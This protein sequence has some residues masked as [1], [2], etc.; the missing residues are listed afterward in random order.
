VISAYLEKLRVALSF[1]PSLARCVRQEVEDH[2]REAVAADPIGDGLAAERAIADFGDPNIIAAQFAVIS[3]MKRTRRVGIAV[4]AV[5]AVIAGAFMAMK[6]RIAWYGVMQQLVVNEDVRTVSE[7]VA[8]I[9]RYA[10]W[11]SLIIGVVG[12]TYIG[13]RRVPAVFHPA[14]RR[15]LNRCF[16]LCTLATGAPVISVISDGVLTALRLS[17]TQWSA[18]FLVPILSALAEIAGA[19]FLVSQ[20]RNIARRA[21]FIEANLGAR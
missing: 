20:V 5:I 15:Q 8:S 9:D 2:L 3:L 18:E 19:G 13:G 21:T 12:W 17:G 16:L 4:I 6:V 1:D 10:F 11:L 7:A 14:F